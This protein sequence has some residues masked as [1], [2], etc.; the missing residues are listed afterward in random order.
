M[1]QCELKL[2][3]HSLTLYNSKFMG[4]RVFP[5]MYK[6]EIDLYIGDKTEIDLYIGNKTQIIRWN[7]TMWTETNRSQFNII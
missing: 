5:V 2:A 4:I 1:K 3:D 7:E 6:T